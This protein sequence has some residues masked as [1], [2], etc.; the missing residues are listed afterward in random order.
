MIDLVIR[1]ALRTEYIYLSRQK[2][3]TQKKQ[4]CVIENH[5]TKSGYWRG[6]SSQ[7]DKLSR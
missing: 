5:L 7:I 4:N 2:R 6:H 3:L 1:Q